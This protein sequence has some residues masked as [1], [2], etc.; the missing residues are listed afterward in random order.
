MVSST[1]PLALGVP[2]ANASASV[3]VAKV[4]TGAASAVSHIAYGDIN[5]RLLLHLAAGGVVGGAG[6]MP[7]RRR[8]A[9]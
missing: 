9:P 1:V 2:P 3:H 6:W 5:G 8:S 4:F 7:R